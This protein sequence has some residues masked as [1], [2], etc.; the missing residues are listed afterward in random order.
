M[1]DN[2]LQIYATDSLVER[3]RNSRQLV[4]FGWLILTCFIPMITSAISGN[5]FGNAAIGFFA[6][7]LL[8]AFV[9]TQTLHKFIVK[10]GTFRA[11]V[12]IDQLQ[13]FL[14]PSSGQEDR[15]AYVVY[16]PGLHIS[17]PWEGRESGRNISLEETSENFAVDVQTSKGN[18]KIK[19][20]V[21]LRADIRKTVAYLGGVASVASDITDLIKSEIIQRVVK[22]NSIIEALNS[23]DVI[24]AYLRAEFKES[25][26]SPVTDFEKRF[27]VVVGDI[28]I[29][30][31]MP[32]E[33]LQKT[34]TGLTEAEIIANGT[35]LML[36]YDDI[37]KVRKAIADGKV[38]QTDFNHARDRFMAA[39]ENI[40]MNLSAHEFNISGLDKLDPEI[41]KALTASIP[42]LAAMQG[43]KKGGSE[44]KGKQ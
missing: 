5:W 22:K 36:G 18:L 6:G 12:T 27:G 29:S 32:S 14:N 43:N 1:A 28:T 9:I 24:N 38:S 25:A 30:E 33:E 21:R 42:F 2:D 41:A 3:D 8:Q 11:F 7:L 4:F 34:M 17:Y 10:V 23:V 13:T 26:N 16:G 37:K 44:Q 39:S 35:A 20:S 40:K 31:I 19:G 15:K